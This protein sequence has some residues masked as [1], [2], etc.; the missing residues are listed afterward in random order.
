MAVTQVST[1]VSPSGA[2]IEIFA[3]KIREICTPCKNNQKFSNKIV[4]PSL[5]MSSIK[6]WM[7]P[8]ANEKVEGVKWQ[9]SK[10]T[11]FR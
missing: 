8:G 4:S 3:L 7:G 1:E 9:K 6:L 5:S 11:L 10:H 2:F